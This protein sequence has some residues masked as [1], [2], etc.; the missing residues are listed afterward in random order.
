MAKNGTLCAISQGVGLEGYKNIVDRCLIAHIE[1]ISHT[2]IL[3]I[4]STTCNCQIALKIA[5]LMPCPKWKS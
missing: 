3:F 2:Y 5:L 1:A 4:N